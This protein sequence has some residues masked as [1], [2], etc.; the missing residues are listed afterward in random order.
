VLN[1]TAKAVRS[2]WTLAGIEGMR[3]ISFD[4]LTR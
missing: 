1:L 3:L 4:P 2:S